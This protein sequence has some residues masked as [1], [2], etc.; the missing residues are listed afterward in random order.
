MRARQGT[1]GLWS[2]CRE[3]LARRDGLSSEICILDIDED[4]IGRL[5]AAVR[6]RATIVAVV[7]PGGLESFSDLVWMDGDDDDLIMST[8][9]IALVD[10]MRLQHLLAPSRPRSPGPWIALG[11]GPM[12]L[13]IAFWPDEVFGPTG[14]HGA[15]ACFETLVRYA[16]EL[17]AETGGST[18]CLTHGLGVDPRSWLERPGEHDVL[19][20]Y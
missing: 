7:G 6:A 3:W 8:F 1:D 9:F 15:P 16:L 10:G 4:A 20:I 19:R 12:D 2:G 13:E 17:R 5:F 18:V 11:R 14:P